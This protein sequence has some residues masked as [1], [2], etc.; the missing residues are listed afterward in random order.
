M[1]QNRMLYLA[2]LL[3]LAVALAIVWYFTSVP[4]SSR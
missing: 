2:I 1:A 3:A 4:S